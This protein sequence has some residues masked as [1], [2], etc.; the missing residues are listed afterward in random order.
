MKIYLSPSK[1]P[2]NTYSWG[3]T[4]EQ[5]QMTRLAHAL[6]PKLEALGHEV[7]IATAHLSPTNSQ[8]RAKEGHDWGADIYMPIHSNASG[9]PTSQARGPQVYLG[10]YDPIATK[11]AEAVNANISA[12]TPHADPSRGIFHNNPFHFYEIRYTEPLGMLPIYLEVE[13]HDKVD[14]A[15]WIVENIEALAQAIAD[16]VA[17]GLPKQATGAGDTAGAGQTTTLYRVQVGAFRD[18]G[19]ADKFLAQVKKHYPDAFIASID[20]PADYTALAKEVLS[21]KWG[22]G[23]ERIDRLTKAGHDARKVQD[24][25]NK[26]LRS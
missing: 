6:K 5:V 4:N 22:S 25:V 2:A 13:F 23:Q 9:S 15:R 12:I 16:G 18:K 21:G 14:T 3:D 1:Q 10:K 20:A 24:E 11:I 7:K 19:N 8:G 26:L 17:Q